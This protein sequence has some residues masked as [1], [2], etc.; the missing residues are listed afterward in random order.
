MAEAAGFEVFVTGDQ[1][2]GYQQNLKHRII[3]I[4][5]LSAQEWPVL[6]VSLAEIA[7]AIDNASAGSFQFVACVGSILNRGSGW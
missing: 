7:A 6:R 3:G 1:N 2:L 4:V 5:T